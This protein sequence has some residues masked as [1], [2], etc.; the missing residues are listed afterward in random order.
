MVRVSSVSKVMERVS[1]R[2]RV[3]AGG[4]VGSVVPTVSEK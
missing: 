1:V 4:A 2:M 3:V